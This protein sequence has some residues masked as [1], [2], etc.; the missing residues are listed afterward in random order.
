MTDDAKQ[1]AKLAAAQLRNAGVTDDLMNVDI[2]STDN[3]PAP[4]YADLSPKP[5]NQR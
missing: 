2:S 4:R 3:I 1:R 5:T